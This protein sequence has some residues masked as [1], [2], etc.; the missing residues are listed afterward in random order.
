MAGTRSMPSNAA[1][2]AAVRA[3]EHA[4]G[5]GARELGGHEANVP[6]RHALQRRPPSALREQRLRQVPASSGR[7]D[8]CTR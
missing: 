5:L 1:A 4:R 8:A 7:S 2:L 3:A 6:G